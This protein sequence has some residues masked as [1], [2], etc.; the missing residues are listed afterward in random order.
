[1]I[2]AVREIYLKN[3]DSLYNEIAGYSNESDL[4]VIKDDILNSAGNLA[5]HL[6]G[7]INFFIGTYLGDTGYV[8]DRDKEFSDKNVAKQKLLDDIRATKLMVETTLSSYS[9]ADADKIYPIDKFGE[10]RTI[11]FVLMYLLAHLNYHL[12]QIN[13]HRRLLTTS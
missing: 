1:M 5:L 6:I 4:W 11:S 10:G 2:I 3:F 9:D 7:N 12:G 8:R 13:Y